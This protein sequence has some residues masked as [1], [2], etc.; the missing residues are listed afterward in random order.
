MVIIH[1]NNIG[2]NIEND[3]MSSATR[4]VN[5]E[6]KLIILRFSIIVTVTQ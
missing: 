4:V 3:G 1:Y 6:M 2:I 5:I